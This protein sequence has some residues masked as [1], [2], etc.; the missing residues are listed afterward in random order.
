LDTSESIVF[1]K[2]ATR[3][4][5]PVRVS[6]RSDSVMLAKRA[7]TLRAIALFLLASL[8][9]GGIQRALAD[10]VA[11]NAKAVLSTSDPLTSHWDEIKQYEIADQTSYFSRSM[12]TYVIQHKVPVPPALFWD[13][14]VVDPPRHVAAEHWRSAFCTSWN[15]GETH[16]EGR[17]GPRRSC[18][19]LNT[20][21]SSRHDVHCSKMPSISDF[22]AIER[23]VTAYRSDD[24]QTK[25][26]EY[27]VYNHWDFMIDPK[28]KAEGWALNEN[29]DEAL[30]IQAGQF[31]GYKPVDSNTQCDL[32]FLEGRFANFSIEGTDP[33]KLSQ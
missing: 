10:D 4:S 16:C 3:R 33:S 21:I 27:R 30:N 14:N 13:R 29:G 8:F 24:G 20:S 32:T 7:L 17:S 1:E 15:D 23:H 11:G 22:C 2:R 9:L 26:L 6:V 12:Q 18:L 19:R 5:P 25:L 31:K 28:T